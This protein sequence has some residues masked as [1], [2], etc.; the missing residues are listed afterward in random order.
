MI[1]GIQPLV[2]GGVQEKQLPVT[3]KTK[4][5]IFALK[6]GNITISGANCQSQGG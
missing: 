6:L 3:P 2:F 4:N 1:L 5:D